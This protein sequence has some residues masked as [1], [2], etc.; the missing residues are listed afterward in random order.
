MSS[1]K[2]ES[3]QGNKPAYSRRSSTE[4]EA[5]E[6]EF[7]EYDV[8]PSPLS[9]PDRGVTRGRLA[10]QLSGEVKRLKIELPPSVIRSFLDDGTGTLNELR[11][12]ASLREIADR[13]E[14]IVRVC[15]APPIQAFYYCMDYSDSSPQNFLDLKRRAN[16]AFHLEGMRIMH[17]LCEEDREKLKDTP[18]ADV[19]MEF[20]N[21]DAR[22]M[23][24]SALRRQVDENLALEILND[25]A[26]QGRLSIGGEETAL[27]AKLLE[28]WNE[29]GQAEQRRGRLRSAFAE[30]EMQ[31]RDSCVFCNAYIDGKVDA[32][33]EDV[34]GISVIASRLRGRRKEVMRYLP[35][36]EEALRKHIHYKPEPLER[37][38]HLA[39]H[40]VKTVDRMG[41]RPTNA[42]LLAHCQRPSHYL[43]F[44][45]MVLR[46]EIIPI[47]S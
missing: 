8:D 4:G 31:L 21:R 32:D 40:N 33:V 12:V 46:K 16:L 9:S 25:A 17:M 34:I 19:L 3:H 24:L 43:P 18:L 14:V 11:D 5:S 2:S 22:L 35:A 10:S 39:I 13:A 27:A 37:A 20:R 7:S 6:D 29:R 44:S 45:V 47:E 41:E 38:V 28:F 26:C 36:C 23:V 15:K 30:Y 42:S 1:T